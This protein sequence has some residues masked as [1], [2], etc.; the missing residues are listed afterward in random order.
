ML[1][2]TDLNSRRPLKNPYQGKDIPKELKNASELKPEGQGLKETTEGAENLKT[3]DAYKVDLSEEAKSKA[4]SASDSSSSSIKS[5]LS[6]LKDKIKKPDLPDTTPDVKKLDLLKF[7]KKS[8]AKETDKTGTVQAEKKGI[9]KKPGIY[10]IT[11]MEMFSSGSG[12]SKSYDGIRKM[13]EGVIGARIYN[14]DQHDEI[15]K[16]IEKRHPDQP[17]ILVG[18]SFGGDT[19]HEVAESLNNVEKGFRKIDLLVTLDSVGFDNDVI[20]ENVKRNLNIFGEKDFFFNDGPHAPRDHR[21]TK[22]YNIIRPEEHRD[23]DDS[24]PVQREIIDAIQSV[25]RKNVTDKVSDKSEESLDKN[26]DI[27]PLEASLEQ[28]KENT[29]TIVIEIKS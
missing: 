16:D 19:A 26:S 23:L 11:G 25:L 21:K 5:K 8:E 29:P 14:W 2:S 20:P 13:A 12:S 6:N 18:H 10:F 24:Q 1:K 4:T 7:K 17:I 15:V 22:V 9:I 28:E 3:K 27:D